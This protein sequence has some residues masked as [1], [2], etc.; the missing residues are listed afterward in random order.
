MGIVENEII[1]EI[2]FYDLDPM[3]VVW[4]GNYVKYSEVARAALMEKIG[5][6]Y[7]EMRNDRVIYPIAKMEMKFI[8]SATLGQK[9]KLKAVLEEFEPAIRIKYVFRDAQTSE[10][11]FKA[12]TMQI[13][14][15]IETRQSLYTA[16]NGL[17]NGVEK[18]LKNI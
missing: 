7:K 6:S 5:Y 11:L 12:T 17:K 3:N 18:C 2:P 8:K 13:C 14:V 1:Q 15:D 4:H 10:I 16:P 9:M